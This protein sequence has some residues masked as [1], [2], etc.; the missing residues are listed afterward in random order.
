MF[1]WCGYGMVS[2]HLGVANGIVMSASIRRRARVIRGGAVAAAAMLTLV[3]IPGVVAAA[4]GD[5]NQTDKLTAADG[6]ASDQ[7]G[8]SVAISG[9]LVVV[10]ALFDD[11][12]GDGTGSVYVYEPD[13]TGA[14][15][16][17]ARLTATDVA[18]G[19]QL[20]FSVAIPGDRIVA[21]APGNDTNSGSA[22][23]F[24]A[25]PE[26]EAAEASVSATEDTAAEAGTE[27]GEFTISR[28]GST[29]AALLVDVSTS[30]TATSGNDYASLP[31]TVTIP[32]GQAPTTA[33]VTP[34]D[35]DTEGD[36]TVVLGVEPGVDDT[37]ATAASATITITRRRGRPGMHLPRYPR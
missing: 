11:D 30:G 28:T 16:Q 2:G 14:Y 4:R 5:V 24:Q 31:E 37:V 23:V 33:D 15:V 6:A 3:L 26:S 12:S 35:A 9:D 19:D 20:G 17:R 1:L 25:G 22:H 36:E 21:G 27:T 7:L 18:A 32:A 29:D 8:V 34:V 13:T 10:G